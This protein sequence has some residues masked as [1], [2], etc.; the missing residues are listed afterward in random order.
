MLEQHF[1]I[2]PKL[3]KPEVMIAFCYRA[4]G[5]MFPYGQNGDLADISDHRLLCIKIGGAD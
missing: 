3:Y 1:G 5:P 2:D 4:E